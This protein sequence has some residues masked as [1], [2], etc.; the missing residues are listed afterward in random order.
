M[1]KRIFATLLAATM[2]MSALLSGCGSKPAKEDA[3]T[4]AVPATESIAQGGE[5]LALDISAKASAAMFKTG[6]LCLNITN[7]ESEEIDEQEVARI[8]RAMRAYTPPTGSLLINQ[9]PAYCYY[10]Q[11]DPAVQGIYDA[12]QMVAM[13]PTN[14]ENY[15]MYITTLDPNSDEFLEQLIIA[16]WALV[17]DHP[18]Y[19]WL[20]NNAQTS[21]TAGANGKMVYF[22]LSNPVK[23][24]EA[25]QK[26]FNDATKAFLDQIDMNQSKADIA[27]AIHD[28]LIAMITYDDATLEKSAEESYT[29]TAHNAFGALVKNDEGLANTAVCDGYS[30]AYEYLLQQA[31]IEAAVIFGKAGNDTSSLGG[32]AWNIVNIDGRWYEV[33]CTWDDSAAGDQWLSVFDKGTDEYAWVSEAISDATYKDKLSHY[34]FRITTA[35]IQNYVSSDAYNYE[36]KDGRCVINLALP[37][38]HLRDSKTDSPQGYAGEKAPIAK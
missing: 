24:Y 12:M 33:D 4:E 13:D 36:T 19:F 18:E 14:D 23:D 9:A 11:L 17:A 32:H 22:G 37:S 29:R 10:D 15:S 20:Y 7:I 1:K 38:V 5:G 27:R 30:L 28:K 21:F 35:E 25:Q 6:D 31:G 34:L 3:T 2:A 16:N 8:D 26:A